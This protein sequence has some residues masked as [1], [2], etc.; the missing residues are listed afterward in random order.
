MEIYY[1]TLYRKFSNL[2][3]GVRESG[4]EFALFPAPS[5]LAA[6]CLVKDSTSILIFYNLSCFW[7]RRQ[8]ETAL[9]TSNERA[10]QSCSYLN[11]MLYVCTC[12]CVRV[13]VCLCVDVCLYIFM[14]MYMSVN[15]YMY[16]CVC[17]YKCI[18]VCSQRNKGVVFLHEQFRKFYAFWQYLFL[19][20]RW[21]LAVACRIF[22]CRAHV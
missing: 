4:Q 12:V 7:A 15:V 9:S 5:V 13:C 22:G 8:F 18:Y 2:W 11:A 19:W 3:L 20:L 16:M 10:P 1:L 6:L 17:V 21:V 14:C